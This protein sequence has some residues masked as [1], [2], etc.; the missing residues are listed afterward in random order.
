M[1]SSGLIRWGGVVAML[2]GVLGTVYFPF[3]AA[4]YL[5]TVEEAA[6][7][8][9]WT[10]AFRSFFEPL[11]SFASP[12]DVYMTY[13]MIAPL[14]TLGFL[15]GVA[16]LHA[17]QAAHAGRLEKWGFRVAFAGTVLGALGSIGAYWIGSVWWGV[18]NISF[19]AFLV[20]A[21]LLFVVGFPLFGIGTLRTKVAPRLGAWLL[22][23]GGLPGIPL[24]T[25]LAG[26]LTPGLLLLNLGWIVLGYAL[27][28]RGGV[29]ARQPQRVS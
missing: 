19:L 11:L 6:P 23:V 2:S 21:L 1:S 28:S 14:V 7:L 27:W 20:P 16:A 24:L 10:G 12:D 5:A 15:A 26:Q 3:H 9:P 29:L 18:V 4:A 13:G 22:T 8:V 25:L 17:R